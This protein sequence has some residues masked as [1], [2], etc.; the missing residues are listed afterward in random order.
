MRRLHYGGGHVLIGD[1]IC[2]A[3]LRYARAL[4]EVGQ[5]DIVTIPIASEGGGIEH[6]H[7]LIGPSSQLFDT[8]VENSSVDPTD[9]EVVAHLERETR[10]LHPPTPAWEEELTDFPDLDYDFDAHPPQ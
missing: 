4:A 7:F 8:P 3:L 6:A 10:K 1:A 9:L 5:A 2:K